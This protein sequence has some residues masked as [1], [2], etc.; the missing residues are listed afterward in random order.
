[1]FSE[2]LG[3]CVLVVEDD[4]FQ[5]SDLTIALEDQGCDVVGP[6]S[7]LAAGMRAFAKARIDAAVLDIHLG[8]ERIYG[9]ADQLNESN[10]PYLFVTG[11]DAAAIPERFRKIERLS[12]PVEL[13]KII[14]VLTAMI[15]KHASRH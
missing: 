9:L 11:Y 5:A 13:E 10:I 6:F 2:L 4:Y 8:A 1:M 3:R 15:S 14:P 12:K 7:T